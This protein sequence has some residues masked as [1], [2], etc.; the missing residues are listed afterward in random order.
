MTAIAEHPTT[1]VGLINLLELEVTG[2][3]QLTCTHC[4]AE[5]SPQGTH[6]T[7]TLA[8]WRTV[9]NDAAALD[10]ATIQ[11]IGGEPTMYPHWVELVE[12]ALSLGRR[13][14]VYSNLFHVRQ[15]WWDV[16]TREG[17]S[18]GT[19]YYSDRAKEHDEI[20]QRK[21]S[22]LR[23][24]ANIAEAVRR[25][26]PLRA[27]IVHINEGQRVAEAWAELVSLGVTRIG[28]DRVRAVGR[29]AIEAP[30]VNELCGRCGHGRAAVLPDGS[31]S[32]CVLSRFMP[33]ANVK[34]KRLA[35]IIGSPE[36]TAAVASIP[37]P[38]LGACGP[39]DSDACD[40]SN[41]ACEPTD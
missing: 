9:I 18:L 23:T 31:L 1:P 11:L 19:S 35:D 26:I 41:N 2:G 15:E 4:L 40:P 21:G 22:Y 3:C 8:D 36:W 20:T 28:T 38:Y 30:T 37:A 7:M 13:V 10:I 12:L 39:D 33:C 25:G 6:G 14:E 32:L 27:G 34:E 24:R 16:F 17:V 29:A 5:S